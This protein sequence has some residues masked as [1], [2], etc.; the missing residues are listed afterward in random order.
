MGTD[1]KRCLKNSHFPLTV[2]I[3]VGF[4]VIAATVVIISVACFVK[5]KNS[6]G[7]SVSKTPRTNGYVPILPDKRDSNSA[8]PKSDYTLVAPSEI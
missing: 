2:F 7:G 4:A 8:T 3:F 1:Q 6:N 5:N